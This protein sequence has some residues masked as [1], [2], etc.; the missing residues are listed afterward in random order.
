M[1]YLEDGVDWGGGDDAVAE[2]EDVAGAAGGL[3]QDFG[4]QAPSFQNGPV[5]YVWSKT[6]QSGRPIA[7][8]LYYAVI[9]LEETE[10]GG[11]VLQTV[12]KVLVP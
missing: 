9:R 8:G 7:R 1:D 12:K 2:V 4:D 11:T 5:T 6:N 3:S 10:G